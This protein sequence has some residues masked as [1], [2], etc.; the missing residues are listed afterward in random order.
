[1]ADIT[2]D[3]FDPTKGVLRKVLQKG[4]YLLD[5]DWNE[6][7]DIFQDEIR[8]ALGIS[9]DNKSHRV[10]DGFKITNAEDPPTNQ[11]TIKAG[12]GIFKLSD[13]RSIALKNESDITKSG[14]S[15]FAGGPYTDYVYIDIFIDEIDSSEDANIVNPDVG[16]ETCVDERVSWTIEIKQNALPGTPPANH[17]FV[18]L[19][20]VLVRDNDKAYPWKITNL[21]IDNTEIVNDFQSPNLL[22]NSRLNIF[23]DGI[24]LDNWDGDLVEGTQGTYTRLG[25]NTAIAIGGGIVDKYAEQT[26]D[27]ET[28]RSLRGKK[29]RFSV[30]AANDGDLQT[31]LDI[32]IYDGTTTTLVNYLFG[33]LSVGEFTKIEVE[34]VIGTTTTSIKLKIQSVYDVGGT[35][36]LFLDEA[37]VFAGETPLRTWEA[38]MHDIIQPTKD[39]IDKA[40]S[41]DMVLLYGAVSES[42][43]DADALL[44][45]D[46]T[47]IH[48]ADGGGGGDVTRTVI[49]CPYVH[50][51]GWKTLAM[52]HYRWVEGGA[53]GTVSMTVLN[54][55]VTGPDFTGLGAIRDV[56]TIDVSGFN[57]GDD[58]DITVKIR[59]QGVN[60]DSFLQRVQIFVRF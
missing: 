35:W 34:A 48:L 8:K 44:F 5:S 13:G 25:G 31:G 26:L 16:Q 22:K 23:T 49:R 21:L 18:S 39:K 50:V 12:W 41:G 27:E 11:V 6:Q 30:W 33:H 3:Q 37:S 38:N 15:A 55:T 36:N 29:L 45:S 24:N 17:F 2:R 7:M 54:Q 28:S 9:S 40:F 59:S 57:P 32:S 1:M 52:K 58:G 53:T 14:F 46:P 10:G 42:F 51:A 19:A 43:T 56:L 20:S 60:L 4:V 47:L